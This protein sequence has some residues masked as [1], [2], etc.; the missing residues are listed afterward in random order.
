VHR[1]KTSK[2]QTATSCE[3]SYTIWFRSHPV[4]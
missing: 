2:T 4:D 1:L 3:I